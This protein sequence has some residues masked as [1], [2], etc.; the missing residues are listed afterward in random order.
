MIT[1]RIVLACVAAQ[2]EFIK[3]APGLGGLTSDDV[4]LSYLPLAHIMDR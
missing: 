2:K 3:Q 1:H 4:F